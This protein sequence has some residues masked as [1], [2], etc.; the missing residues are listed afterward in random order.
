VGPSVPP[1]DPISYV[2]PE[3][4]EGLIQLKRPVE[5]R[6]HDL[7]LRRITSFQF[8][9]SADC[10]LCLSPGITN[11]LELMDESND[12]LPK[13]RAQKHPAQKTPHQ[14]QQKNKFR[15]SR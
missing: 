10:S 13:P 6:D 7:Q 5:R 4:R 3:L 2:N 14:N 1:K 15:A 9:H 12:A 8:S 11:A